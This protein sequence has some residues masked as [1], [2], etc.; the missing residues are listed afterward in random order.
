MSP[1]ANYL[2][3]ES[4]YL[5]DRQSHEKMPAPQYRSTRK[6]RSVAKPKTFNGIHRRRSKR[7][8]W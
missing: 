6:S 8:S 5:V 7:V 3:L 1:S 2:A 4:E